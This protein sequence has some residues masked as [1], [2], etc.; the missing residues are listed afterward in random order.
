MLRKR[1][2]VIS[3]IWVNQLKY[4]AAEQMIK[5]SGLT[6]K[7]KDNPEGDIEIL[8]IGLRPGEKMY[9]ELLI[10]AKSEP[11]EHPLI[12]KANEKFIPYEEF[13]PKIEVFKSYLE[14]FDL[15]SALK[16]LKELVPTWEVRLNSNIE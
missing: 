10:D 14:N 1:W 6:I 12:F 15:K 5:L 13:M 3:S 11:T 9:E 2:R 16:L 4:L 8:S 7:N